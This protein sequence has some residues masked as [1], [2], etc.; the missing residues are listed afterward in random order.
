MRKEEENFLFIMV[1]GEEANT[2][3]EKKLLAKVARAI[4]FL[5]HNFPPS[6]AKLDCSLRAEQHK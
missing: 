6:R 1:R 4:E 5:S 2:E 3:R